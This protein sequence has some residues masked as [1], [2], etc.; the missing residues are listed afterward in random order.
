MQWLDT[1]QPDF[2]KSYIEGEAP[3][4]RGRW[5]RMVEWEERGKKEEQKE[6]RHR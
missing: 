1:E 2:D 6:M 3:D 4:A 5:L